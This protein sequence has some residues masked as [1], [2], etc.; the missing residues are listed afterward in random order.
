MIT[1]HLSSHS[2]AVVD[3]VTQN[4]IS[5]P[6]VLQVQHLTGRADFMLTVAVRDGEELKDFILDHITVRD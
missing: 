2:R 3:Q 1:V 4:M 5:T 6:H